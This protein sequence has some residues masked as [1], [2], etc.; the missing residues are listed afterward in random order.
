MNDKLNALI[1]TVVLGL[2]I[3]CTDSIMEGT[4]LSVLCRQ[5]IERAHGGSI[6]AA[7]DLCRAILNGHPATLE[8][9]GY[10]CVSLHEGNWRDL[11]DSEIEGHP[12]RST[13]VRCP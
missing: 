2:P 6:D 4:G 11:E 7:Y 5:Y 3:K 1:E 8:L 12:A 10:A 13:D 9:C